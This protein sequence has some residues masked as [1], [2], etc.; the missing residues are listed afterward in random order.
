MRKSIAVVSALFALACGAGDQAI[1]DAYEAA[2][3][4]ASARGAADPA[5]A[6]DLVLHLSRPAAQRL[7]DQGVATGVNYKEE[8]AVVPGLTIT[9]N[10]DLKRV[11]LVDKERPT[12]PSCLVADVTLKGTLRYESKLLGA[13]RV[14]LDAT[15]RVTVEL[16]LPERKKGWAV[17]AR[18]TDV[19][20]PVVELGKI[21]SQITKLASDPLESWLNG[22]IGTLEPFVLGTFTGDDLPLVA[23]QRVVA[24]DGGLR[25]EMQSDALR[26]GT[27]DPTVAP[28][29]D[30]LRLDA[31]ASSLVWIGRREAFAL[32]P[33]S[34]L[35]IAAIPDRLEVSQGRFTLDFRLWKLSHG[36]WWRDVRATGTAELK[37]RKI[38][39]V[40]DD[41]E[42]LDQSKG[43]T[44]ADPLAALAQGRV[45]EEIANNLTRSLPTP[46][47]PAAGGTGLTTVLGTLD[48]DGDR[49]LL[50][51]DLVPE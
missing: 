42:Q 44:L 29:A 13:D 31:A 25:V 11:V 27:V 4:E 36:S 17:R 18:L 14:P 1:R 43:A 40:A 6:P 39:L 28:P 38:K 16:D 19:K 3:A 37:K 45:L 20:K 8:L 48:G 12:C 47:P 23:L 46:P 33:Q 41:V 35:E 5:G 34:D 26:R 21:P 51:G 32:G 15:A 22:Q 9:P 7:V 24:E 30:G 10:V 50:T 49:V 2:R